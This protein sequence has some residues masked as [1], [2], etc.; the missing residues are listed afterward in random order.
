[1]GIATA[2]TVASTRYPTMDETPPTLHH[3]G[4]PNQQHSL[5]KP[6]VTLWSNACEYGIGGYSDNGL[7]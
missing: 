3:Q 5:F 6:S 7:A 4:G 1:M 2:P